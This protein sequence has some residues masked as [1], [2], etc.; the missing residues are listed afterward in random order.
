VLRF[1]IA[2]AVSVRC[3]VVVK[4]CGNNPGKLFVKVI[5]NNDVRISEFPLFSFPFLSI[6]F[7]S[8]CS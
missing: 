3:L 6:V 8:W 2:S 5:R 7:I 1:Y 4:M